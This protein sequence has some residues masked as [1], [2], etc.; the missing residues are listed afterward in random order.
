MKKITILLIMFCQICLLSFGQKNIYGIYSNE[1][2]ADV[3]ITKDKFYL[4]IPSNHN[5]VW[6]NDTLAECTYNKVATNFIELNSIPLNIIALQKT[7]IIQSIDPQIEDSIR[8]S[9]SIPYNNGNLIIEIYTNENKIFNLNYKANS[10]SDLMLPNTTRTIMFTI[11]PEKSV[12]SHTPDGLF[13]GALF[14][15]SIEYSIEKNINC[16]DINIPTID[17]SFFEKYY[18]KGDYA[19][20]VNDSIIW[21]GEIYKKSSE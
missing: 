21:K 12:L 3:L 4:I 14:Y 6:Y 20:I 13:Y 7:K 19:R 10:H 17:N 11:A 18:I 15:S 9:F 2:G 1:S 16:I 8:I 5:P